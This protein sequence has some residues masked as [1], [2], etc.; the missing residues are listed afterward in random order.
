MKKTNAFLLA[1]L[2]LVALPLA[3]TGGAKA[4]DMTKKKTGSRPPLMSALPSR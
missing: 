4:D 3:G 1:L 2:L